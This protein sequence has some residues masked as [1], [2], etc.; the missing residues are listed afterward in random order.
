MASRTSPLPLKACPP[1]IGWGLRLKSAQAALGLDSG[2]LTR[3]GAGWRGSCVA[4][5]YVQIG[6]PEPWQ[7][8]EK[9][10]GEPWVGPILWL[11]CTDMG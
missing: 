6:S 3:V 7:S 8:Q 5:V 4:C 10:C 2:V 11:E 1:A 9:Y